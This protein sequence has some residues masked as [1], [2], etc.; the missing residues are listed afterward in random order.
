MEVRMG[1]LTS[2]ERAVVRDAIGLLSTDA[3]WTRGADGRDAGGA[4]KHWASNDTCK[5]CARGAIKF[6]A[7]KRLQKKHPTFGEGALYDMAVDAFT[8]IGDKFRA[9][10]RKG[11]VNTNDGSDTRKPVLSRLK[12]MVA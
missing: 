12:K 8:K 3:A 10:F 2:F 11:V 7:F 5:R 1:N 9:R 4:R 6:A